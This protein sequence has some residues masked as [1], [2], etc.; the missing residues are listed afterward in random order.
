MCEEEEVLD[1]GSAWAA[2]VIVAVFAVAC[3]VV[4]D[5]IVVAPRLGSDSKEK[6]ECQRDISTP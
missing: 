3:V 4:E 5:G 2:V 6:V 1:V